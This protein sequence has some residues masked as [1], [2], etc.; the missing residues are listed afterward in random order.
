MEE[1]RLELVFVNI[2]F[3]E[4]D[5][6]KYSVT[7]LFLLGSLS[8]FVVVWPSRHTVI[9]R[10]KGVLSR[11]GARR[12]QATQLVTRASSTLILSEQVCTEEHK[13]S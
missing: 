3:L 8:S 10:G 9:V 12:L 13:G 6:E 1:T 7:V 2:A 11:I 4:L 5:L